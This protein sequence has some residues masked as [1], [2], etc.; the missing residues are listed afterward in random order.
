MS[1]DP[2]TRNL[3]AATAKIAIATVI[4]STADTSAAKITIDRRRCS[5]RPRSQSPVGSRIIQKYREGC[6]GCGRSSNDLAEPVQEPVGAYSDG[7]VELLQTLTRP[8]RQHGAHIRRPVGS[9]WEGI[10]K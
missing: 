3:P 9:A 6:A 4:D 2:N 1:F 5:R 7:G 10:Q 8:V